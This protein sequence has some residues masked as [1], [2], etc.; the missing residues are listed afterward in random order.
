LIQQT[1]RGRRLIPK[2]CHSSGWQV[3]Y[4]RF[5]HQVTLFHNGSLYN[6]WLVRGGMSSNPTRTGTFRVYYRDIDHRSSEFENAPMPYAQFFSGG[7]ALHGSRYM[8]D[9][10]VGHSHGCVNMYVEDARVLWRLTSKHRLMVHVYG[11]WA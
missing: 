8:V 11:R 5:R 2:T 1:I 10:F 7:E 3:C 6:S 9:P 4:D